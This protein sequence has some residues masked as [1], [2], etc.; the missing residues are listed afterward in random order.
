MLSLAEVQH[1]D[2]QYLVLVSRGTTIH[3]IKS[4]LATPIYTR[5]LK[6][7][8]YKRRRSRSVRVSA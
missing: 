5:R 7:W 1:F 2:K 8:L 3:N 6:L 4:G